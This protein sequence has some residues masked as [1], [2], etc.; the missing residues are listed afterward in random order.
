MRLLAA[1][2]LVLAGTHPQSQSTSRISV[3]GA[4]VRLGLRCQ[5]AA[6][7]EAV[8]GDAD[9]DGRLDAAEL[10]TARATV[11]VYVTQRYRLTALGG[12]SAQSSVALALAS[13][14]P[15]PAADAPPGEPWVEI[16][17]GATLPEPPRALRAEVELFLEANP[18]HRDT[19]TVLW[20]DEAPR[21]FVAGP[22]A[23]GWM[24]E[25]AARR[26]PSV[27]AS[28][29]REGALHILH[30]ADHL[31]FLLALL[32]ASRRLASLAATVT[33]FTAAHSLTLAL[34]ALDVLRVPARPVELA[35]A[36]SIVYVALENVL[37]PRSSARWVE[38]FAFGLVHGVGFA[39]FLAQSLVAEPLRR[40]ALLGFNLGVELGQLAVVVPLALLLRLLPGRRPRA[41]EGA[42]RALAPTWARI[43][44]S[45]VLAAVGLAWFA[46]RAGWL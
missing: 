45:L 3:A 1:L 42:A 2:A 19:A 37:A 32:L 21:V 41:P 11:E 35:I 23:S 26:R 20:N 16:E 34:A 28:F 18:L 46:D 25:P 14:S 33:A 17:L 30:G 6:L 22:E 36:L 27:V 39:S 13:L 44:G 31:A 5:A 43:A 10:A 8:S 9:G 7:I 24:F 38:A 40:S 15:V 29:V 4:S 12:G